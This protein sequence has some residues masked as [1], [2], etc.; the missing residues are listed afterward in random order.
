[1]PACVSLRERSAVQHLK[2][3]ADKTGLAFLQLLR[4]RR[5]NFTL[6]RH[7]RALLNH[8]NQRTLQFGR[9]DAS[10][11]PLQTNPIVSSLRWSKS[12]TRECEVSTFDVRL[13]LLSFILMVTDLDIVAKI[14]SRFRRS[15]TFEETLN[16]VFSLFSVHPFW[17]IAFIFRAGSC[18]STLVLRP[19]SQ[20][21][22]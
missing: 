18:T 21:R 11:L 12:Q 2:S 19:H 22:N 17:D 8:L 16:E 1:M 20:P 10:K 5:V 7:R 3:E 9:S 13:W 6:S 4:S 15:C 14:R